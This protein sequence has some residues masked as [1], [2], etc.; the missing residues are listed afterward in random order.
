[1]FKALTCTAHELEKFVDFI[2][3]N[4]SNDTAIIIVGDHL[5]RHI[6][7][8]VA[9]H[10]LKN[11]KRSV[12]NKFIDKDFDLYREQINHFDLYPTILDIL[13]FNINDKLGLGY[14]AL[15]PTNIDYDLYKK[16]L[17]KNIGNKSKFYDA[18]WK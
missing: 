8:Y 14:S 16:D 11:L 6:E 10:N 12:Y 7:D 1:M 15:K 17:I 13:D 2:Y 3:R 4:Y 9:P 5:N 18:F